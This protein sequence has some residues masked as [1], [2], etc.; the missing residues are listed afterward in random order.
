MLE[1]GKTSG[2]DFRLQ[3]REVSRY[4]SP[5]K[6]ATHISTPKVGSDISFLSVMDVSVMLIVEDIAALMGIKPSLSGA[7]LNRL[8]VD[9]SGDWCTDN[10]LLTPP[11]WYGSR[12]I[13]N[14]LFSNL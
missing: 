9:Y 1:K 14:A 10:L 6:R 5:R 8:S 2:R 12:C 4:G 3:E 7:T 13:P 11:G